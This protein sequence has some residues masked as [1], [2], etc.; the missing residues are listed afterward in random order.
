MDYSGMSALL[1]CAR[2]YWYSQVKRIVGITPA[3]ES[4]ALAFGKA[5]H[6]LLEKYGRAHLAGEEPILGKIVQEVLTETAWID[7]PGDFRNADLL[8]DVML[9][10]DHW[11]RDNPWE[12]VEIE[13]GRE[14][15]LDY[16]EAHTGRLDGIVKR[17]GRKY[18][19]DYKSTSRLDKDWMEQYGVSN[20]FKLYYLSAKQEHDVDGVIVIVIHVTKTYGVRIYELVLEYT[21][22]D[23][24]EAKH[25]YYVADTVRQVYE[26]EDYW[27]RNTSACKMYNR[28]CEYLD[29]CAVSN[30]A[31]RAQLE[32][33][34]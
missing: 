7:P 12:W 26:V 21:D 29:L 18:V 22:H 16:G 6:L 5:V 24:E 14:Q 8:E 23:L 27:P 15:K 19:L 30:P 25:D 11:F 31:L 17:G 34:H 9:G 10:F 4:P 32:A 2:K 3:A 13:K 20:Q 33:A 28:T 1:S